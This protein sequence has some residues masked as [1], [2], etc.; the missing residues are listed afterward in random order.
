M[1]LYKCRCLCVFVF[2]CIFACVHLSFLFVFT[3]SHL[4]SLCQLEH[5]DL[6][7]IR[8]AEE[9][10]ED[11]EKPELPVDR[12]PELGRVVDQ[13]IRL[14]KKLL[15]DKITLFAWKIII[16]RNILILMGIMTKLRKQCYFVI[17]YGHF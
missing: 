5:S 17:L 14:E 9:G 12:V 15:Y 2:L 3:A 8:V 6:A 16:I 1:Y 10:D 11:V 13:N 4:A 7:G